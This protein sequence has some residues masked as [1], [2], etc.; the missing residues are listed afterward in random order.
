VDCMLEW[1]KKSL[2]I[3]VYYAGSR[4]NAPY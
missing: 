2:L 3:E 1:Q 4:E